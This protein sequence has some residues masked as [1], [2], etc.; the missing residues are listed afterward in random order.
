MAT[1]H[2]TIEDVPELNE[3]NEQGQVNQSN[4]LPE[5]DESSIISQATSISLTCE[6]NKDARKKSRSERITKAMT[7]NSSA[8]KLWQSALSGSLDEKRMLFGLLLLSLF[9]VVYINVSAHQNSKNK[10]EYAITHNCS[11]REDHRSFYVSWTAFCFFLWA[12]IHIILT[13]PQIN[14]LSGRKKKKKPSISNSST[15]I[16]PYSNHDS[17]EN[18]ELTTAN[19]HPAALLLNCP[20]QSY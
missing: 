10:D 12:L 9:Y 11:C 14:I 2:V 15:S 19:R 4:L 5:S 1:E 17:D 16:T 20:A 18:T 13:I 8:A 3:I 6:D 7:E